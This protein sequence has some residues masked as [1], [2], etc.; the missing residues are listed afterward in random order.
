MGKFSEFFLLPGKRLLALL[1]F[2]LKNALAFPGNGQ[3]FGHFALLL[4]NA[5]EFLVLRPNRVGELGS[6]VKQSEAGILEIKCSFLHFF[7]RARN[8]LGFFAGGVDLFL[9]IGEG[10]IELVTP[11]L[12]IFEGKLKNLDQVLF[13]G[14]EGFFAL[15]FFLGTA[16]FGP[17][18]ARQ[19]E[20]A[21]EEKVADNDQEC[22]V[23]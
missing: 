18:E 8:A 1:Q 2:F 9:A 4:R 13:S 7:F 10:G 14:L 22:A 20:Q 3:V 5:L 6:L 21:D 17:I 19:R 12:L 11:L 23:H 16:F 15:G